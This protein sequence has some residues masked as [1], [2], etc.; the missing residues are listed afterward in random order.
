VSVVG[1]PT[2]TMVADDA[3]PRLVGRRRRSLVVFWSTGTH[4]ID[5]NTQCSG[6]RAENKCNELMPYN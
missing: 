1:E 6:I 4:V 3:L 5:N 2:P